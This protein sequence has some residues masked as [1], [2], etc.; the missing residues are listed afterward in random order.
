MAWDRR[1]YE[2]DL[3]E[4]RPSA[5]LLWAL[6]LALLALAALAALAGFA[7]ASAAGWVQ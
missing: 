5:V 6:L 1:A 4:Y 7:L 3:Q 2:Q